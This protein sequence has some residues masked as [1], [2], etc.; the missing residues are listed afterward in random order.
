MG[1]WLLLFFVFLLWLG[2]WI[3]L[4]RHTVQGFNFSYVRRTETIASLLSLV[5][6]I[7]G[8]VRC[9][10][11]LATDSVVTTW[12]VWTCHQDNLV[13]LDDCVINLH[14]ASQ[15]GHWLI[16]SLN[17][18]NSL[19]GLLIVVGSHTGFLRSIGWISKVLVVR[20]FAI[21]CIK[22]WL[23]SACQC[24]RLL[25]LERALNVFLVSDHVKMF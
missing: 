3:P 2:L 22:H 14:R 6:L 7:W 16:S 11:T 1:F 5:R 18:S 19:I 9:Q 4:V 24:D 23:S 8:S 10:I 17:L 20:W 13:F 12:A 21:W 25:E 15:P